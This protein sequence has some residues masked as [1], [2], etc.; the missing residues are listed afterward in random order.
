MVAHTMME[1]RISQRYAVWWIIR[2]SLCS[3][4]WNINFFFLSSWLQ[5]SNNKE[6]ATKRKKLDLT[7]IA[8]FIWKCASNWP[9]NDSW[10]MA[11]TP[12]DGPTNSMCYLRL[13][14]HIVSPAIINREIDESSARK[15]ELNFKIMAKVYVLQFNYYYKCRRLH[16]F[17][18]PFSARFIFRFFLR[19]FC[20]RLAIVSRQLYC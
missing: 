12:H 17:R 16:R 1:F 15:S 13:N 14:Q 5:E 18:S 9:D 11:R 6:F 20:I 2:Y 3:I 10:N 7:A 8:R 4:R 19:V